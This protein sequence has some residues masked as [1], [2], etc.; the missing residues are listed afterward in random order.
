MTATLTA[1]PDKIAD[2]G[3][4]EICIAGAAASSP[5]TI[6]CQETGGGSS[7]FVINTDANGNGCHSFKAPAGWGDFTVDGGGAPTITVIV[8]Q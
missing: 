4:T 2:C 1:T 8:G 7:S 6:K 3:T 5:V